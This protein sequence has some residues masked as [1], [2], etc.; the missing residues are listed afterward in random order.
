MK[1]GEPWFERGPDPVLAPTTDREE[2]AFIRCMVL[3]VEWRGRNTIRYVN[4][5]DAEK[6]KPQKYHRF[7]DAL[8]RV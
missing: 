6:P 4:P 7:V 5:D 1:A 3:P 8:V 2:T